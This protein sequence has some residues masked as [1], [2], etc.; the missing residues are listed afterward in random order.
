L[1]AAA[2]HQHFHAVAL[3][4]PDSFFSGIKVTV[5]LNHRRKKGGQAPIV[6]GSDSNQNYRQ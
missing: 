3:P 5:T 2:Y 4:L 1:Q 6:S